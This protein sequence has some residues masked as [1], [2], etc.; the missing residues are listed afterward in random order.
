[1]LF[2]TSW[3]GL[4][5]E[6]RSSLEG[7]SLFSS[8]LLLAHVCCVGEKGATPGLSS[9]AKQVLEHNGF[10][11]T[12]EV[13]LI[14]HCSFRAFEESWKGFIWCKYLLDYSID[15]FSLGDPTGNCTP[16]PPIY[17]HPASWNTFDQFF[18]PE[19]ERRYSKDCINNW[20][21][22]LDWYIWECNQF[23]EA[24]NLCL[25]VCVF[26]CVGFSSSCSFKKELGMYLSMPAWRLS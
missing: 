3:S 19:Y 24:L 17:Q 14:A 13:S 22:S 25:R 7:P 10:L 23:T 18:P 16:P 15:I 8:L 9:G 26:L 12:D 21:L 6:G 2:V 11:S 4:K 1:M 5:Q 20:P